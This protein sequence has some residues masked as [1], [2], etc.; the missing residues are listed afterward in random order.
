M[1]SKMKTNNWK[2]LLILGLIGYGIYYYSD[3]VAYWNDAESDC[4]RF[5]TENHVNPAWTPDPNDNK[6][7][8]VNKYVRHG[9]VIVEL[10]QRQADHK[11]FNSRL[12]VLGD[13]H[14]EIPSLLEQWQYR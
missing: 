7:F 13:G 9:K 11:S 4:I 8:V 2:T 6:L 10:G 14:I 3:V 5:A 12:C 1:E